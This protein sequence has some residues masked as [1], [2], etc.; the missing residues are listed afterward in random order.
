METKNF[1]KSNTIDVGDDLFEFG[2]TLERIRKTSVGLANLLKSLQDSELP[3]ALSAISLKLFPLAMQNMSAEV[4]KKVVSQLSE[5][6]R[7]FFL[8]DIDALSGSSQADICAARR[9]ISSQLFQ[10]EGTKIGPLLK[11]DSRPG[12]EIFIDFLNL[13]SQIPSE[14]VFDWQNPS[15]LPMVDDSE[16][17]ELIKAVRDTNNH[18]QLERAHV[19]GTG[20]DVLNLSLCPFCKGATSF[21]EIVESRFDPLT[22]S[23]NYTHEKGLIAVTCNQCDSRFQPTIGLII[24]PD[25]G[26]PLT[27]ISEIDV[28][29]QTEA[30]YQT[31]G[32][33]VL[34][35]V[36]QNI[37]GLDENRVAILNDTDVNE[38]NEIPEVLVNLLAH[39]PP[40]HLISFIQQK[41]I[42]QRD[43]LYAKGFQKNQL[44]MK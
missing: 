14:L 20:I 29:R 7:Q 10:L 40:A 42:K 16:N 30:F 38:L 26:T 15:V 1:E 9:S 36:K 4:I 12:K 2:L 37:I 39:T 19:K 3:P 23:E 41:N 27:Y 18:F 44:N 21:Q 32:K 5:R 13:K 17:A 31:K 43:V 28:L 11:S 35:L 34:S 33:S 25:E 24:K 6:S 8:D 22:G